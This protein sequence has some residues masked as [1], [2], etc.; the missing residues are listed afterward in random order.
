MFLSW[1]CI[2]TSSFSENV[3]I[4]TNQL[5]WPIFSLEK[6]SNSKV[7]N[8]NITMPVQTKQRKV[9]IMGYRAVGKSSLAVQFVQGNAS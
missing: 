7:Q 2:P 5:K 6:S 8:K 4:C 9:A 1:I 3:F